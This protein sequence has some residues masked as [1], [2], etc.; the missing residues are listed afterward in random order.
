MGLTTCDKA[1]RHTIIIFSLYIV[2]TCIIITTV[3]IYHFSSEY[4]L[5]CARNKMG[6]PETK[7]PMIK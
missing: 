1:A 3:M 7:K 5:N 6:S 4:V 2:R